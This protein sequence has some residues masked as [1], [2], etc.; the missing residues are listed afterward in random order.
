MLPIFLNRMNVILNDCKFVPNF[1]KW[2][3]NLNCA[4][5]SRAFADVNFLL[6]NINDWK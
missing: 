3:L 4:F 1:H 5:Q 2:H 6:D